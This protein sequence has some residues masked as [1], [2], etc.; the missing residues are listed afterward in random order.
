MPRLGRELEKLVSLLEE[1]LLPTT[2]VVTS[3]GFLA[4]RVTGEARE[5][6][7]CVRMPVGSVEVV[8]ILECRDRH[9][10]QD[11]TWIEQ[12]AQK[13][14][15]VLASR[16]VAVSASGFSQSAVRKAR[17]LG[18]DLRTFKD[19]DPSIVV[20]WFRIE[21]FKLYVGRTTIHAASL[22][23]DSHSVSAGEGVAFKVGLTDKCLHS[24][25]DSHWYSLQG[26]WDLVQN[27]C[28]VHVGIPED[29]TKIWRKF[30]PIIQKPEQRLRFHAKTVEADVIALDLEVEVWLETREVPLNRVFSYQSDEERLVA[31]AEYVIAIDGQEEILS[32]HKDLRSGSLSVSRRSLV[33]QPENLRQ[34]WIRWGRIQG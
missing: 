24:R 21:G 6:D 2:A 12:L 7:V 10:V 34:A 9:A 5:V 33:G 30:E 25:H 1:S 18:I 28:D 19:L 16:A 17:F 15:D 13:R 23:L 14:D 32:I 4:D 20:E 26:V 3:P 31:I 22:T 29:G 27:R 8:V 11:V